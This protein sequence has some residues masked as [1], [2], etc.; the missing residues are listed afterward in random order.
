MALAKPGDLPSTLPEG[1]Q[2]MEADSCLKRSAEEE[3]ITEASLR[4]LRVP[5]L[6]LPMGS[7][8]ALCLLQ[9]QPRS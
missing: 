7:S 2:P 4:T 3:A 6:S 8:S 5:T 1:T 9:L